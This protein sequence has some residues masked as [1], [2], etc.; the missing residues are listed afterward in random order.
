MPTKKTGSGTAF[1]SGMIN[2]LLKR[3]PVIFLL[4][5]SLFLSIPAFCSDARE[6]PDL[7][8]DVSEYNVLSLLHAYDKN[9]AKLVEYGRKNGTNWIGYY[10]NGDRLIDSLDTVVHEE[11][12]DYSVV[13]AEDERMYMG[14]N[15]SILVPYTKIYRS[16]EMTRSVPE[17]C[18]TSR[19]STYISEP[20]PNLA[21]NVQGVYGLLNE[22]AAYRWGM[23]NNIAMFGYYDRFEDN[24]TTWGRFVADGVSNRLAYA[25]FKYYILHYLYYAKQHHPSVYRQIMDNDEFKRAYRG[26][27]GEFAKT[28]WTFEDKLRQVQARLE[29]NGYNVNFTEKSFIVTNAS[30]AGSGLSLLHDEYSTLVQ[31]MEKGRYQTIHKALKKK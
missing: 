29:A 15:K 24:M 6:I 14:K 18:R 27:E 22:F 9:G 25:E 11:F 1:W 20:I 10:S 3:K 5:F 8:A 28:I 23:N 19:F 13:G 17:R 26:T 31:E 12:H 4:I 2:K 16:K 7:N 30:G 21:S